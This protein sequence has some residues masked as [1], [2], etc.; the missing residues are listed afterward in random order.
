[1]LQRIDIMIDVA[2]AMEYLHHGYSMPVAHCDL[3]PSNELLDD[4]MV[5]H[6]SDFGFAKLL[7]GGESIAQTR[8]IATFGYIALVL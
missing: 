8:T 7:G 5:A 3:K 2:C 1:M 6:V 4:D